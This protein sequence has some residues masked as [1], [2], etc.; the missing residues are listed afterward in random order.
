[1]HAMHISVSQLDGDK[2]SRFDELEN[3]TEEE[4]GPRSEEECV[5]LF[6]QIALASQVLKQFDQF[7]LCEF[8]V[9]LYNY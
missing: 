7:D 9:R 5:K 4:E 2:K 6:V 1:V 8:I 3:R